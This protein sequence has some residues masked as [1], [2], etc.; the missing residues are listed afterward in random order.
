MGR[1]NKTDL[2]KL[3]TGG[4][5]MTALWVLMY[6]G[7][8]DT[9]CCGITDDRYIAQKWEEKDRQVSQLHELNIVTEFDQ[10]M[11]CLDGGVRRKS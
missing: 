11:I 1:M 3:L 9:F 7:E 4:G 2:L 10:G 8:H 6:Y 5:P